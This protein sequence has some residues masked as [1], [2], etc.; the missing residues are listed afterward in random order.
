MQ[1]PVSDEIYTF[2][3]FRLDV[4]EHLLTRAGAPV[5]LKPKPFELL[6][7]LVRRAGRIVSKEELLREVW[8][9]AFVEEANLSVNISVLRK[10]LGC[11][12]D[13]CKFI[14]TVPKRGYRFTLEVVRVMPSLDA[15]SSTEVATGESYG[16]QVHPPPAAG[17]RQVQVKTRDE[18]AA[19]NGAPVDDGRR[20]RGSLPTR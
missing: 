16:A 1:I 7:V 9:E 19:L 6:V 10:A 4:A 17:S 2:G 20:G 3:D 5:A 11:G 13:G 8:R 12:K 14:E 18:H 15:V